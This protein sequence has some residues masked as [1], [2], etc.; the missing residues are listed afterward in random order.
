MTYCRCPSIPRAANAEAGPRPFRAVR[1]HVLAA[2]RPPCHPERSARRARSRGIPRAA[3]AEAGPR[4][5]RAIRREGDPSTPLASLAALRMTCWSH[6]RARPAQD[7]MPAGC[8]RYARNDIPA[9][10]PKNLSR[11]RWWRAL[12]KAAGRRSP[13]RR[14][15]RSA[16]RRPRSPEPTARQARSCTAPRHARRPAY[17]R[18]R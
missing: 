2:P 13:P 7:D 12:P 1:R 11:A 9:G 6:A 14:N 18:T 4:P 3:N 8:A 5:F 16:A 10:S 17:A 15:C